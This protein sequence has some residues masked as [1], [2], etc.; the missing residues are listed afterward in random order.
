VAAVFVGLMALGYGY[1]L[2]TGSRRGAALAA[3]A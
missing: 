3:A 1:F 2:L